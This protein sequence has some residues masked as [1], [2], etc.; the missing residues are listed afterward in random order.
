[1]LSF[2]D[3]VN[4]GSDLNCCHDYGIFCTFDCRTISD[5]WNRE[6]DVRCACG[7]IRLSRWRVGATKKA[8]CSPG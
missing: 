4:F 6:E 7:D 2:D 3:P 1:M 8:L 5:D